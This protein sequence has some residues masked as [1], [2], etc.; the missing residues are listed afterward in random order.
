[1]YFPK[2]FIFDVAGSSIFPKKGQHNFL[3]GFLNSKVAHYFLKLLAPTINYQIGDI[4]NL[5]L[6]E[7][8]HLALQSEDSVW[9]S[10]KDWDSRETSWD[11]E[12]SPLLGN[13]N[14]GTGIR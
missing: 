5:P 1:R 8:D 11:F 6:I 14:K 9:L 2:G 3:N 4:K 7:N 13:S 10:K 12:Q